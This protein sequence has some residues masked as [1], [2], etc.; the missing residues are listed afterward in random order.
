MVSLVGQP[1]TVVAVAVSGGVGASCGVVDT[2]GEDGGLV[3]DGEE[4]Y[5]AYVVLPVAAM[6]RVLSLAIVA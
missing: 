4:T 6:L 5:G 3:G 2:D 1:V